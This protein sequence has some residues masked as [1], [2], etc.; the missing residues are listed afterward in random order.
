MI[1]GPEVFEPA[2]KFDAEPN[3][4]PVP[5]AVEPE[6]EAP[7]PYPPFLSAKYLLIGGGTAC[8]AAMETILELD[9]SADVKRFRL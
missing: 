9:G 4:K 2:I 6:S 3:T 7:V 1:S 8:A 5:A